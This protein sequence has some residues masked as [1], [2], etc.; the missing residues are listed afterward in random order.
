MTQATASLLE[1]AMRLTSDERA[2]L[3]ERLMESLDTADLAT[4]AEWAAELKERL[5]E[6]K[7]G[8]VQPIPWAEVRRQI[9]EDIDGAKR[10]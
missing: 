1:Q 5:A 2:D 7:D 4:D 9:V 6:L 8:R 10:S 3:A